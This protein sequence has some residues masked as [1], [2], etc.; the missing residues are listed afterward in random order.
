MPNSFG[1]KM[2]S[3]VLFCSALFMC[4]SGTRYVNKCDGFKSTKNSSLENY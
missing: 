1:M 3:I 2:F 4:L